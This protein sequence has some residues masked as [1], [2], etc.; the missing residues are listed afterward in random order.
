MESETPQK[1]EVVVNGISL[2]QQEI[3]PVWQ[4]VRFVLPEV[5]WKQGANEFVL[6]FEHVSHFFQTRGYGARAFRAAAVRRITF[7][8]E[9]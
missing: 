1:L 2:G 3:A 7:H 5:A 4:T 9:D 6:K 8:R